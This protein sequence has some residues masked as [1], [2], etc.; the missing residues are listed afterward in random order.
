MFADLPLLS[1][2]HFA[3]PI[4]HPLRPTP[5]HPLPPMP[6]PWVRQ[7][8]ITVCTY[9]ELNVYSRS[10][11]RASEISTQM[12]DL[13]NT[14]HIHELKTTLVKVGWSYH[15]ENHRSVE[16]AQIFVSLPR[17]HLLGSVSKF[18][19]RVCVYRKSDYSTQP[20]KRETSNLANCYR[21]FPNMV[22][23]TSF[24]V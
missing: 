18:L 16:W 10:S 3:P 11:D 12:L 17:P 24:H 22:M 20:V 21:F 2:R 8:T 13:F 23:F 4:P 14:L 5:H 15:Y 1:S 6:F 7:V 19:S 9:H